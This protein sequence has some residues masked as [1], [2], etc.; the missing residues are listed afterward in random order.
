MFDD[1]LGRQEDLPLV[2]QQ[3]REVFARFG[4]AIFYAQCLEQQLGLMLASMY[5]SDF[6]EFPPGSRDE[7][8]DRELAKTLGRMASDLKNTVDISS[9]L[10]D[11]LQDAV[12]IRNWLAHDYFAQRAREITLLKGREKMISELQ[13]KADFF[14]ALDREFT[15]IMYKWLNLHGISKEDIETEK[16]K[17]LRGENRDWT[18]QRSCYHNAINV[19]S[20]ARFSSNQ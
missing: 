6:F 10:S 7:F 18:S 12:K 8:Y 2:A 5:N 9:T 15:E 17:F 11:R 20:I 19:P 4:L 1:I 14:E 3:G 16:K 13:E